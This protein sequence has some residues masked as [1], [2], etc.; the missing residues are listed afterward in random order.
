MKEQEDINPNVF[1]YVV[2]YIATDGSLSKDG[3][4]VSITS[5]DHEHLEKIKIE[6][7]ITSKITRKSRDKEKDKKY[8]VL[9]I[10]GVSNYRFLNSIGMF[11]RKT[12]D[13]GALKIEGE[14]FNDF[15]RGVIDG[16]GCIYSWK[17]RGNKHTQWS[18]RISGAAPKFINWLIRNLN[19]NKKVNVVIDLFATP[20]LIDD[21]A[22]ASLELVRKDRTGIYHVAGATAL[23]CYEM[24]TT[25]AEVFGFDKSLINPVKDIELKRAAKRPK[26]S[27][28]NISKLEQE[29]IL[30]STF[31][32]S[33]RKIRESL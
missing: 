7:G 8:S 32:Q 10:G 5:K 3:R 1:W 16:D 18:L 24:A 9:Q 30:M 17:H 21:L 31:E 15:L 26:F 11:S 27:T 25:V 23:S 33:I 14:Y 19:E 22:T 4:H 20:T 12:W 6:F 28:L 13:M 2:G 29:G